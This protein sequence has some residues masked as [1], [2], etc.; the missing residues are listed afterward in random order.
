MPWN[1][2]PAMPKIPSD[3]VDL[4]KLKNPPV[5]DHQVTSESFLRDPTQG[6]SRSLLTR[7]V[8]PCMFS[9]STRHNVLYKVS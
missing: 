2:S 9:N 8:D 1:G 3:A 6:Y 4:V 5:T 7:Y